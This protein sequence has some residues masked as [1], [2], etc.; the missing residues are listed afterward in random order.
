MMNTPRPFPI[1]LVPLGPG[2]QSDVVVL[3]VTFGLLISRDG[4]RPSERADRDT[5]RTGCDAC[6]ACIVGIDNPR[7]DA[8]RPILPSLAPL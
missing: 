2:S 7:Q 6:R 1:P 3:R 8:P 4:G 5:D